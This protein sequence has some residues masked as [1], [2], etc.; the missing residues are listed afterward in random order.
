VK[1]VGRVTRGATSA[2]LRA[3]GVSVCIKGIVVAAALV[4]QVA[5]ASTEIV[6]YDLS[7]AT[8]AH[9]IAR[10]DGRC[11]ASANAPA[12]RTSSGAAAQSLTGDDAA[13]AR[14]G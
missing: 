7:V 11:S 9:I 2:N 13:V 8:T 12:R 3:L 10:L 6:K 5:G 1:I 14:V 4:G